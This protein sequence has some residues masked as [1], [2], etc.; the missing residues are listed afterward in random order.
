MV[1]ALVKAPLFP[2]PDGALLPGELLPLHVFEPRYRA[3]L[4][5]ARAGSRV[6]AIATLLPGWEADYAGAP[7]IAEIVGL[8]RIVDDRSQ[9]DGTSDIV[10]QGLLRAE[11]AVELESDRP[12]RLAGLVPCPDGELHPAEAWRLRCE[13]LLGIAGRLR[14]R[15]FRYDLTAG[16]DVGALV[17]RIAGSLDLQP[18]HKVRMMQAIDPVERIGLLLALLREREHR[19]RLLE[20][21]P[22]LHA[23]ALELDGGPQPEGGR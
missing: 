13:L 3:M 17:D 12:Y 15:A 16:F 22:S 2:L 1:S 20:L 9:P 18:P 14:T 11:V 8:G 5:D 10:L 21:V 7:A 19:R 4:A 23:F 6:I